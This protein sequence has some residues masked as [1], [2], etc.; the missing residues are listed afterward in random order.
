MEDA[1]LPPHQVQ[2]LPTLNARLIVRALEFTLSDG[3]PPASGLIRE[4]AAFSIH[5]TVQEL[6]ISDPL[7]TG[8]ARMQK[9]SS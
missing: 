9:S 5:P 7:R 6:G 2:A 4:S 8:P 1:S 3:A